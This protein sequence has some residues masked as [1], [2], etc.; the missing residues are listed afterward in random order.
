M[1][2]NRWSVAGTGPEPHR[3]V[4][5]T[6]TA[7]TAHSGPRQAEPRP[8]SPPACVDGKEEKPTTGTLDVDLSE[9]DHLSLFDPFWQ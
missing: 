3:H 7:Q 6:N 5:D 4:C 1:Q 8:T 9:T 2:A